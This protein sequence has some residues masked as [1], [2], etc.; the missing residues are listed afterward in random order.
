MNMKTKNHTRSMSRKRVRST[1]TDANAAIEGEPALKR[2][3]SSTESDTALSLLELETT[4]RDFTIDALE[5]PPTPTTRLPH[6][7]RRSRTSARRAAQRAKVPLEE[8]A[9]ELRP[10]VVSSLYENTPPLTFPP[11][12]LSYPDTTKAEYMQLMERDM[13]TCRS[14]RRR[15]NMLRRAERLREQADELQRKALG[16]R[17]SARPGN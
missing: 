7:R 8:R 15:L 12:F 13:R 1:D 16:E 10:A 3:A 17:A 6:E 4:P 5:L 9:A 14:D 11:D 2:F